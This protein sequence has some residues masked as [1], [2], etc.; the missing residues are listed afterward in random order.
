MVR[1]HSVYPS[2][3]IVHLRR[4]GLNLESLVTGIYSLVVLTELGVDPC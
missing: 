2:Q 1:E 3:S 4:I